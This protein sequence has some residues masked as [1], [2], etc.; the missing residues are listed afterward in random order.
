MA[1][2]MIQEDMWRA[3]GMTKTTYRNAEQGRRGWE[4][5]ELVLIAGVLKT[6]VSDL[7]L[8]A[9]ARDPRGFRDEDPGAS[10]W[11]DAIG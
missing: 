11:Q 1:A 5:D 4:F 10:S 2:G 7:V 3:V 8:S 6:S 9:E